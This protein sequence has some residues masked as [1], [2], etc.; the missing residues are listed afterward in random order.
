MAKPSAK[1]QKP[2]A[3]KSSKVRKPAAPKRSAKRAAAPGIAIAP[4]SAAPAPAAD[5]G[6][7]A[8]TRFLPAADAIPADHVKAL[9]AD[10]A[11]ALQNV[12]AGVK[13]VIGARAALDG[14]IRDVDWGAVEGLP[15]LARAVCFAAARV[16]A[17]VLPGVGVAD[18]LAEARKLRVVLLKTAEA[19]AEAGRL[20]VASVDEI[21]A[22]H[23]FLDTANDCVDLAALFRKHR[24]KIDGLHALTPEQLTRAAE[25]G[26]ELVAALK[27][28]LAKAGDEAG[29]QARAVEVR[30]RLWTLL[31]REHAELRRLASFQWVEEVDAHVPPLQAPRPARG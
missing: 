25:L 15:A 5:A 7:A 28:R 11:L 14:R 16:E 6:E 13:A 21:R 18:K 2:R 29:V 31:L 26:S 23:G 19:L 3:K 22:G 1:A 17:T 27:P 9:R 24:A 4:S 10:A 30:D 8:H 12:E 20:P